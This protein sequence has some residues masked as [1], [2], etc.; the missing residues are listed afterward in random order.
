MSDPNQQPPIRPTSERPTLGDLNEMA[1]LREQVKTAWEMLDLLSG[2]QSPFHRSQDPRPA[3]STAIPASPQGVPTTPS[4]PESLTTEID[5]PEGLHS[6]QGNPEFEI[7]ANGTKVPRYLIEVLNDF[8]KIWPGATLYAARPALLSQIIV[9]QNAKQ[10]TIYPFCMNDDA[11]IPEK[12]SPCIL[13]KGH[14]GRHKDND[15][16]SWA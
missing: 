13:K 11:N 3:Q 8:D 2:S 1:L 15:D 9:A 12:G 16:G 4:Q 14:R 5:L 10:T 7:L 6:V